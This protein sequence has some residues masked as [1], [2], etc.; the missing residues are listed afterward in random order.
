MTL[1][2][3][4]YIEDIA[5]HRRRVEL[6]NPSTGQ[7]VHLTYG[8]SVSERYIRWSAP[9][10]AEVEGNKKKGKRRKSEDNT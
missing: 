4:V 3:V 6:H 10:I 9:R 2:F 5:Y 7:T 8:D 1:F